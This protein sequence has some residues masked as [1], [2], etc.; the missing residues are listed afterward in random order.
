MDLALDRT[1]VVEVRCE[2]CD[3]SFPRITG[4]IFGDDQPI[5]FYIAVLH[6]HSPEGRI[7]HLAVAL[8]PVEGVD[9][10]AALAVTANSAN[11]HFRFLDWCSTPL[12]AEDLDNKLDREA[13]LH[14]RLR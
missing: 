3:A 5:G 8:C 7:A 13:A 1:E 2:E 6:G 9:E 4:A 14:S 10:C 11:F 12:D